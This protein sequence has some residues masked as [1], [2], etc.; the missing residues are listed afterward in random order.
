MMMHAVSFSFIVV[1]HIRLVCLDDIGSRRCIVLSYKSA[2]LGV[3]SWI[4][5][6]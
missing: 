3:S 6:K 4:I 1:Q 2:Q 5:T